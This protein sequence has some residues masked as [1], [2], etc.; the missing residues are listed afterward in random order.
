M[1]RIYCQDS[2][3][4]RMSYYKPNDPRNTLIF[5]MMAEIQDKLMQIQ[6][7]MDEYACDIDDGYH[8]VRVK[9]DPD[10]D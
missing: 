2:R 10:E 1:G 8:W 4:D 7:L 6:S 3:G 5:D 9:V